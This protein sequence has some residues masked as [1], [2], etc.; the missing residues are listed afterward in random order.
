MRDTAAY[1]KPGTA[2]MER[3]VN[4]TVRH[5]RDLSRHPWWVRVL[6]WFLAQLFPFMTVAAAAPP[7]QAAGPA[8]PAAPWFART[9]EAGAAPARSE[10]PNPALY[11]ARTAAVL[12]VLPSIA[13]A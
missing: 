7:V 12:P 4:D 11:R 6:A 2:A 8:G 1:I 10:A 9:H 5:R 3:D 13:S